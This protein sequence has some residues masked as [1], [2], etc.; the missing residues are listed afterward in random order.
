MAI[1]GRLTA[2]VGLILAAGCRSAPPVLRVSI[3]PAKIAADGNAIATIVID[4]AEATPRVTVSDPHNASVEEVSREGAHWQARIRAGV[5]PS[6]IVVRVESSSAP[7]AN[8]QLTTT[9]VNSDRFE[10]GTPDFLRLDS[11]ADRQAFRRWFTWLAEAQYFQKPASRPVEIVDCAALI[12]YAY[13]E[14]LHA[15]E[16]GWAESARVPLVPALGAIGKYRYPFTPLGAALFRVRGDEF[17]SADATNGTFAQF[18]DAQTLW[19]YNTHA[20]GRNLAAALAGDLLFYRHDGGRMPFHSMIY[21]GRSQFRDDGARFVLYH[22]GPDSTDP[23]EIRRLTLEELLR[24]P[25]P[26]WRPIAANPGFL[27]VFRWN[28]LR[29]ELEGDD[30]RRR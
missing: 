27:G 30:P 12:R 3:R 23:G 15:H 5:I 13:R 21:L 7:A 2:I 1:W 19:R 10:D 29:T 9:A 18:A 17:R 28:I 25:Q 22:T 16:P 14:S 24:Y 11:E 4:G 6:V 26:D 8:L 20:I